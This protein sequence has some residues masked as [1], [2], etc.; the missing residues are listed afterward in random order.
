MSPASEN[1]LS[2]EELQTLFLQHAGSNVS[3]CPTD[4]HVSEYD[5]HKPHYF[6]KEQIALLYDYFEKLSAFLAKEF[7]NMCNHLFNAKIISITEIFS[8][9]LITT[10]QDEKMPYNLAIQDSASNKVS[11]FLSIPHQS[12][13]SWTTQLLG[14][15]EPSES[16]QFSDLEL[17][18]LTEIS[19]SFIKA[20]SNSHSNLNCQPVSETL[21]RSVPIQLDNCIEMCKIIFELSDGNE[22][23]SQAG[24]IFFSSYLDTIAHKQILTDGR[25]VK[26]DYK[27]L[28]AEHLN[29]QQVD[30][31]TNFAKIKLTVEDVMN[32]QTDDVILLDKKVG[33]PVNLSINGKNVFHAQLVQCED[34]YGVTI[35]KTLINGIN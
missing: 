3:T 22:N 17:S 1:K 12:A 32:L 16:D 35:T 30:I 10:S 5:F 24:F 15:T 27:Q 23:G 4:D 25:N 34:S 7:S 31:V 18:L 20:F 9:N 6:N 11:G 26:Q 13:Q 29:D 28:I 19:T 2:R 21:S 33:Q 14:E 8:E